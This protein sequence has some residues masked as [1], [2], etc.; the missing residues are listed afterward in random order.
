MERPDPFFRTKAQ[1]ASGGLC[2]TRQL[3][4]E[5]MMKRILYALAI[6]SILL[7]ACNMPT[8]AIP[9][10]GTAAPVV[11]EKP[12]DTP[13]QAEDTSSAAERPAPQTNVKC[14]ELMLFLDPALA[15]GSGCQTLPEVSGQDT[16]AFAVNPQYT[17]LTLTGYV[18]PD[19]FFTPKIFVYPIRRYSELLPDVIPPRLAA[20][21]ALISGSPSGDKGLPFLPI[22][23]AGQEFFSQYKAISF[24]S[25]NG[26]RYLTQYSQ[27]FDPINN[28]ELFYTFQGLTSDGKYWISAILPISNP[29]LPADGNSPPNGQS[30]EEFGNNFTTYIADLATQ[31]NSQ[32]PDNYSPT[33]RMLDALVASLRI[34][35]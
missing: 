17:E 31:L 30:Q 28:H 19:R 13:F 26:I 15:S 6:F 16:P 25:G 14:N 27:Y 5:K 3:W 32:P 11:S 1:A 33:I 8:M 29:I 20:L 22:F 34:Q 4:K 10:V 35:P 12:T 23:N 24:G 2:T 7:F 9:R 21:Q 18:L